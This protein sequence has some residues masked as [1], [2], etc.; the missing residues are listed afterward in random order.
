MSSQFL[1]NQ[2]TFSNTILSTFSVS[3]EWSQEEKK[4]RISEK[5]SSTW[6]GA[7][8]SSEI[9]LSYTRGCQRRS[10]LEGCK[11]FPARRPNTINAQVEFRGRSMGRVYSYIHQKG[12]LTTHGKRPCYISQ[13]PRQFAQARW[14]CLLSFC[15]WSG[16]HRPEEPLEICYIYSKAEEKRLAI[17][18]VF[19]EIP[20]DLNPN[21]FY[22]WRG[23]REQ[24]RERRKVA[25]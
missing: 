4:A 18:L 25:T 11:G 17:R 21:G 1:P 8:G 20:P 13:H 15:A 16:Q 2:I 23:E 12:C 24:R 6:S 7:S 5:S 10:L 9:F 19:P 3:S 14:C 22:R